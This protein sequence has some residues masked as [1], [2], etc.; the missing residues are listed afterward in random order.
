MKTSGEMETTDEDSESSPEDGNRGEEET[1]EQASESKPTTDTRLLDSDPE[2]ES[3]SEM[4]KPEE[5]SERR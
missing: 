3:G 5:P 1:C 2:P 4:K